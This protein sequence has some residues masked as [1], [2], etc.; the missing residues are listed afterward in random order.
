M[1]DHGSDRS[2]ARARR[3][4]GQR[5]RIVPVAVF[6]TAALV[7]SLL[8]AGPVAAFPIPS[9]TDGHRHVPGFV[10]PSTYRCGKLLSGGDGFGVQTN[11][12]TYDYYMHGADNTNF[13]AIDHR[14]V[15]DVTGSPPLITDY[16]TFKTDTVLLVAS[17]DHGPIPEEAIESTVYGSDDPNLPLA[18]WEPGNIDTVFDNGPTNWVSDDYSTLWKF[19]RPYR[20]VATAAGGPKALWADGDNEVDAVCA[21]PAAQANPVTASAGPDQ[22]VPEGSTVTLDGTGSHSNV[23]PSASTPVSVN[24]IANLFGAGHAAAP[25]PCGSGSGELPP[26]I[27]LNGATGV[28][29]TDVAGLVNYS[30]GPPSYGPDGVPGSTGGGSFGGISTYIDDNAAFYVAGVFLDDSEPADPAPPSLNFTNNHDFTELSPGLRQMFFVGDGKTSWGAVQLFHPPAGATRLYLGFVDGCGPG[31][32]GFFVDNSGTITGTVNQ[33]GGQPGP[34]TYNW[35]VQAAQGPPIQLSSTT[36]AKPSFTAFDDGTY[37]FRLTASNGATSATDDVT[38]RVTNQN[39]AITTIGLDPAATDGLA[40]ATVVFTDP[41]A[42]DTHTVS[43]D[44]GDG[45]PAETVA[46]QVGGTGWGYGYAGHVYSTTG[47]KTVTVRVVD[48]DG[49][50][51][52]PM[53]KTFNVG[54]AGIGEAVPGTGAGLWAQ[55]TTAP[56]TIKITGSNNMVTGL[57]HSNNTIRISGSNH[58]LTGGTEYR[59]T[60]GVTGSG[61]VIDPAATQKPSGP[62]PQ[63]FTFGDYQPGG[64]AALAAGARYFIIASSEC[65]GGKWK[66]KKP[67]ATGLYNVPCGIQVSGADVAG[68]VTLVAKGDIQVSGSDT[69]FTPFIDGLLFFTTSTGSTA[70]DLSGSRHTYHGAIHAPNG[71]IDLTG[72]DHKLDC[73]VVAQ[74]ARISGSRNAISGAACGTGGGGTAGPIVSIAAPPVLV[75]NPSIELGADKS[76]VRPGDT[77]N[78]TAT[79]RNGLASTDP[80][81]PGGGGELFIPVELGIDNRGT[82]AVTVAPAPS[83]APVSYTLEYHDPTTGTWTTLASTNPTAP[84][85]QRIA[86][87]AAR[88]NPNAGV[89]YPTAGPDVITGTT[90]PAGK[91]ASWAAN[92]RID[93]TPDQV[94]LLLDPTRVDAIRNTVSLPTS[95][96]QV[97]KITRF[98][99]DPL[100]ELRAAPAATISNGRINLTRPGAAPQTFDPTS[101]PTL[102]SLTAGQAATAVASSVV[103]TPTKAAGETDVAYLTR[104]KEAD[105]AALFAASYGTATAGVGTMFAPQRLAQ[106]TR[107]VPVLV[108]VLTAPATID[109]GSV[110]T[111]TV[112]LTNAGSE[113]AT[114]TTATITV[115]GLGALAVSGVPATINPGQ[116]VTGS[117]AAAVPDGTTA[118]YTGTLALAWTHAG[119]SPALYGP[120]GGTATISARPAVALHVSKAAVVAEGTPP[121]Q[122][123]YTISVRND[124]NQPLTNVTVDDPLDSN[125]TV[126]AGTATTSQGTIVAGANATDR[127]VTVAVGSI[128]PGSLVTIAFRVDYSLAQPTVTTTTNQATVS[129]SELAPVPSDDPARP[130]VAD[131]TVTPITPPGGTDGGGGGN[132]RPGPTLVGCD[133]ADGATITAPTRVTCTL[134]PQPGTSVRDWTATLVPADGQPGEGRPLGT[135]TNPTVGVDVDPTLLDN[136]IWTIK[137]TT[138][139]SDGGADIRETTLIVDGQ[140]KLGDYKV[141]Y[142]DMKIPVGGMPVQVTRSYDSFKRQHEGDFGPGWNVEVSNFKVQVNKPLG[143]GGWETFE[144]GV[145]VVIATYCFRGHQP[146]YV[147]VTWPDGRTESFDFMPAQA[148]PAFSFLSPVAYARRPG[149]TGTSKLEPIG[150]DAFAMFVDNDNRNSNFYVP[151]ESEIYNPKQFLLTARDGSKYLLDRDKGLVESTDRHGNTVKVDEHGITSSLG[152]SI[153]FERDAAHHDRITRIIG[154]DGSA[155]TY[156]YDANGDLT[157][158]TDQNHRVTT[159]NYLAGHYLNSLD[160]PGPGVLRQMFYDSDGRLIRVTDANGGTAEITTDVGA[161]TEATTTPDGRQ[162]T[163][164]THD[165][166]GN[167][168]VIDELFDGASHR[169]TMEWTDADMLTRRTD[170]NG[171]VWSGTYDADSNLTSSTDGNGHTST[172]AYEEHGAVT[173]ATDPLGNRTTYEYDEFGDQVRTVSPVGGVTARVFDTASN[174]LRST[175]PVG[176]VTIGT[177][178]PEG[179]VASVTDPRGNTT[180]FGYDAMGRRTSAVDAAGAT[181]RWTTDGVGN[182]TSVTDPAG[183]QRR[184]EYG[185]RDEVTKETDQAG[186]AMSFAYDSVGNLVAAT[187]EAGG[188]TTYAYDA[189]D[190]VTTESDPTGATTSYT[191]DGGG[192]LRT[193]RDPAGVVTTYGLDAGGRVIDAAVTGRNST[194]YVLDGVGQ[195]LSVTDPAGGVTRNEWDAAGRLTRSTDQL[196]RATRATYDAAGRQ[197]TTVNAD[198]EQT[199]RTYDPAGQLTRVTD[200]TGATLSYTYDPSGNLS[201][202]TDELNRTTSYVYDNRNQLIE[203]SEPAGGTT[204]YAYDAAGRMTNSTS[205]GG[206]AA[207]FGYDARGLRTS[208][209]DSLGHVSSTV[210]DAAGR[211]TRTVDANNNATQYAYDAAGRMIAATDATGGTARAIYQDGRLTQRI[212]PNGSVRT[213]TYD[214]AGS[215]ASS[216]DALGRT[217]RS[218]YDAAGRLAQVTNARGQATTFAYD[219]A[220]QRIGEARPEG[221]VLYG[222]DVAGRRTSMLDSTGQTTWSYDDAGRTASVHS[223]AGDVAYGYDAAG[224]RSSMTTSRGTVSYERDE[225]GRVSRLIDVDGSATQYEWL[226]DGRTAR[227]T[228]PNGVSTN[229]TYDTAG[230]TTS[231]QHASAGG[232]ID[233][234]DYT[235]DPVG[236]PLSVSSAAGTDSYGY[237]SLNRVTAAAHPTGTT[238]AFQYD[239]AGNITVQTRNG[240]ATSF[241]YD[242]A[243]QMTNAASA[244]GSDAFTYDADGNLTSSTRGD[245]YQWDSQGMLTALNAPSTG[246]ASYAYDG[247]GIRSS[248]DGRPQTWDRLAPVPTLLADGS[249]SYTHGP[250]G[251][252]SQSDGSTT[253]PLT[254]A[255]GSVRH[256]TRGDGTVAGSASYST[257]GQPDTSSGIGTF[258]YAGEQTDASG[259]LHL[260]ARQYDPSIGRFLSQDSVQPNGPSA[261]QSWNL[262]SYA[263][264]NPMTNADPTGHFVDASRIPADRTLKALKLVDVEGTHGGSA[265][266]AVGQVEKPKPGGG[267]SLVAYAMITA[268]AVVTSWMLQRAGAYTQS[269]L[270][271]VAA[272]VFFQEA[273]G[274]KRLPQLIDVRGRKAR[275]EEPGDCRPDVEYLKGRARTLQAAQVQLLGGEDWDLSTAVLR[276]ADFAVPWICFDF[277]GSGKSH[278]FGVGRS[279]PVFAMLLPNEI[280]FRLGGQHAEVVALAGAVSNAFVPSAMGVNRASCENGPFSCRAILKS[281]G[282]QEV[283]SDG[284]KWPHADVYNV[285]NMG[286]W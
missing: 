146:H 52:A 196:G 66:P 201:T 177:Y 173:S 280:P 286:P 98:S 142:L 202:R 36:D 270:A 109:A 241:G 38:V 233:R 265:R 2:N 205:G 58:Q 124:G 118:T 67:L 82:A 274:R 55:S 187:D 155:V 88:P 150:N 12:V 154:P 6:A 282:A 62:L 64:R 165:L 13:E 42:F 114:G 171:N 238:E 181:T 219:V 21:L 149:T 178:T 60:I 267:S 116:T 59:T 18:Q 169:T 272:T 285:L 61:T 71:G 161:R 4:R 107:H 139:G 120:V 51:S 206:L 86:T 208:I 194:S 226:P 251:I 97:R 193:E 236:N 276:A 264:G 184:F 50:A 106:T 77:I 133:P 210:Y 220:G 119:G 143:L 144:C 136:G 213:F 147:T 159:H 179:R 140:L 246:L 72:S 45:T 17:I 256:L 68:Q 209:T 9:D 32:P 163:V 259:L 234:F 244:A 199:S 54:A 145:A 43:Y 225:A 95:G 115:A 157:Q 217:D 10:D 167:P 254:D 268:T 260:R 257:Y 94:R 250:T 25:A 215:L 277:V 33:V 57:T 76:D 14:W 138:R 245:T 48:D 134:D 247:D 190:N 248:V 34:V 204:T 164:T 211:P 101:T 91:L 19:S 229:Y 113:P 266:I 198:G 240:A 30:W 166:R 24:G 16:E 84:A 191:Y 216:T 221:A 75:P 126:V 232:P 63:T 141:S 100:T 69:S 85:V 273:Q 92:V 218:T 158:V 110:A 70:V 261:T 135:G 74:T 168:T 130:G 3:R 255:L 83:V 8:H 28:T 47:D 224:R 153:T 27:H 131:P 41:G 182:I 117:A 275:D 186:F 223:P 37:T 123:P 197:L 73:G 78:Y 231:V 189:R 160:D 87:L 207:T 89:V 212:D 156:G 235:L 162:T 35:Q 258:G 176:A 81:H 230:R 1:R 31:N 102:A 137:I 200:P 111:W 152:P 237:D 112:T 46:A 188:V 183:H 242:A 121:Y 281:A 148:P 129:T 151:L 65:K 278:Q 99:A 128:A 263:G 44:W 252:L 11:P 79:L 249:S 170:P 108:P 29:L 279:A 23:L 103:P 122:L 5:R 7:G 185:P 26:A 125:V 175:D 104:L 80:T 180:H 132:G 262:Y 253:Y 222:Y 284:W 203:R 269:A 227:F 22:T 39:P 174:V 20:Y 195:L 96:A 53:S 15:Q 243:G 172:F 214:A 239:P 40:Q 283:G 228:R 49:G 127:N 192:R 93:L 90:V 105:G 271:V 56:D